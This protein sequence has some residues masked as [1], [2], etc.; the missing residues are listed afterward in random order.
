MRTKSQK[1]IKQEQESDSRK[2]V[3]YKPVRKKLKKYFD[4]NNGKS[5]GSRT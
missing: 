5:T 4:E 2:I 3:I 1:K